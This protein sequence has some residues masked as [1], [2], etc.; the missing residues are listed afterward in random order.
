MTLVADRAMADAAKADEFG[1]RVKKK[2]PEARKI[3]RKNIPILK[4]EKP[5][6]L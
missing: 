5:K 6:L 1:F 2:I 4:P 3:F